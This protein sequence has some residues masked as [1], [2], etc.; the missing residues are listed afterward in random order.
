LGFDSGLAHFCALR[1]IPTICIYTGK[2]LP[3]MWRG[4]S[5]KNNL[6]CLTPQEP[7]EFRSLFRKYPKVKYQKMV[8]AQQVLQLLD[9]RLNAD[10]ILQNT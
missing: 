6:D 4:V 5:V 2:T 7:I 9:Q 10:D 1:G 3:S 8:E